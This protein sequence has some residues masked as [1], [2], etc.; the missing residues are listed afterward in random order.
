MPRGLQPIEIVNI[1]LR[2]ALAETVLG[3][4]IAIAGAQLFIL[5][6]TV[7][8]YE[9][10]GLSMWREDILEPTLPLRT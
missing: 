6:G 2:V 7:A 4:V 9:P 10:D 5:E 3:V 8:A 1:N